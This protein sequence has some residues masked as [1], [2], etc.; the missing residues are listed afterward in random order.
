[1]TNKE[2]KKPFKTIDE[3]I[4]ILESDR[5]LLISDIEDAKRKLSRYG[6]YEIVNGYKKHFM[7]DPYNDKAGFLEGVTFEHMYSLFEMDRNIR[8]RVMESIEIF[9]SELKQAVAYTV[10]E[11]I[12]DNQNKYISRYHYNTG[13]KYY[14][15]RMKKPVYPIDDLL[16][17]MNRICSTETQP[18]KH[19]REH[20]GNVPPW[21]L[22]KK[23][24]F[25]NLIWW[26]KLL[27]NNER[28]SVIAKIFGIPKSFIND[29][30]RQMFGNILTLLLDYRNTAAHGGR[31]FNHHSS[32]HKLEYIKTLQ[33][34]L[35]VSPADY[36]NG[37]GQSRLGVLL[38]CL[39]L[40]VN[41]EPAIILK[42][43]ID[44]FLENY[45]KLYSTDMFIYDEMEIT[46]TELDNLL[47]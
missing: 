33:D 30:I 7:V 5:N 34:S 18:Y 32:K 20:H 47:K 31:I 13:K 37:K 12:S 42:V 24:T 9:E 35:N 22:V 36:R 21:I 40:F 46:Q 4:N 23:L 16:R 44:Y 29:D 19:Y 3:Q 25:G 14:N 26:C 17:Q 11:Q 28:E 8:S 10:A 6:Y 2:I 27:K 38:K 43:G 1:M 39:S 45:M 15:S 41:K